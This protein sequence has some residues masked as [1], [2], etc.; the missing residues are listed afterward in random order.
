MAFT[1]PLEDRML[2]RELYDR[3]ADS[4]W[5]GDREAW[6]DCFTA[7]GAWTSHLFDCAGH[8]ALRTEW[9]KLWADFESLAFQCEIGA[10]EVDGDTAR[11][12]SYAREIVQPKQAPIFKLAGRYEDQLRR[13]HGEW[14]FSRRDYTLMIAEVPEG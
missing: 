9:D 1:G 14:R 7:D 2:I 11:A 6:I 10:I 12:R 13:E 8:D 5:R 3:Y 4:G